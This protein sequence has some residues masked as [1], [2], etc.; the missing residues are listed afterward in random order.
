M[1][2][3]PNSSA[4][5][6][7][8]NALPTSSQLSSPTPAS[9][10]APALSASSVPL[11]ARRN[12][13]GF[14]GDILS[15]VTGTYFIPVTTVL[16]G[17]VSELTDNKALI[18]AVGTAWMAVWYLPQ[19][20]GAR[21]VR[22]SRYQK[23]YVIVSVTIGRQ[24]FLLLPLWLVLTQAQ[25]P[26]LTVWLLLAG[27]IVF[28]LTDAIASV[29]WFD[30]ISRTLS[31]RM[32]GRAV[33]AGQLTAS[34][35]GLGVSVLVGFLLDPKVLAFPTNYAVLMVLAW[36]FF[37]L[38]L[39]SFAFVKENPVSESVSSHVNE[40]SFL[41][42]LKESLVADKVFRKLL[43]ARLLTGVEMMG[44]SFYV[45][46]I[47]ERLNLG[48][49]AIG[50]FTQA[51]IIGAIV[52]LLLFGWVSERLG[53]RRVVQASSVFQFVSPALALLIAA[54]PFI[55]DLTPGLAIAIM[56]VVMALRG[57]IEHSLVLGFVGYCLDYAP[58][59]NRAMYI[60]VL[61][62]VSGLVAL[63]PVLGGVLIQLLQP[64][65]F[66]FAYSVVFGLAAVLVAW[67]VLLVFRLPKLPAHA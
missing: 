3:T 39:V 5:T 23:K 22:G 34:L 15:F 51:L 55:A 64:V 12:V 47:K 10:D 36:A 50:T 33:T 60:G 21:M 17:L 8:E 37:M 67:G 4:E 28:N 62:T 19:L 7:A 32:R 58:D 38:S 45:V 18:G 40:V 52:G 61:N 16:V 44:A 53:A 25:Q 54:V 24:V 41:S 14:A 6:L 59:R 43:I 2:V 20:F 30:I 9:A 35:L 42:H 49:G 1:A 48:D 13:L 29:A 66:S 27:I 56:A 11:D 31:P 46:F 26:L 63:T 57:A 65:G